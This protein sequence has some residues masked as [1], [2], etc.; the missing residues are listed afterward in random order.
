L[1]KRAN[2]PTEEMPWTPTFFPYLLNKASRPMEV[3]QEVV[4]L[5]NSSEARDYREWMRKVMEDWRRN[6]RIT[7]G[8]RKDVQAIERAVDRKLGVIPS[9]PKVEMKATI[10]AIKS[11]VRAGLGA[12]I[13]PLCAVA[14]RTSSAQLRVLR[15]NGMPLGRNLQLVSVDAEILPNAI[16]ELASTLVASLGRTHRDSLKHRP[17]RSRRAVKSI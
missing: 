5:R 14:Q 7:V 17:N 3:L 12:S 1:K 2:V 13:L 6:G 15:V 4:Q 8:H 11:L 16:R 9:A 10:E